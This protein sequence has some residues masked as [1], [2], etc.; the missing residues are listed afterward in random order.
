MKIR[1]RPQKIV[2]EMTSEAEE[3]WVMVQLQQIIYDDAGFV[4]FHW[5]NHSY[6][7]K[8]GV[9]AG[10]IINVMNFPY[11]GDLVIE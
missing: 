6:G 10:P 2:I 1:V 11:L 8:K 9:K 3:V 4:P 5:Q 7:V